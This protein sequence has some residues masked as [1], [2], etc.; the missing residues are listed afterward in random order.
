MSAAANIILDTSMNGREIRV[1]QIKV[2]GLSSVNHSQK[3]MAGF[4]SVPPRCPQF[5]RKIRTIFFSE[6]PQTLI[7]LIRI[8]P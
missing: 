8:R 5:S 7:I 4:K 6:S 3:V 1:R 2:M